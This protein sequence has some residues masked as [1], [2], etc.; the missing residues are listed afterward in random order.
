MRSFAN[1]CSKVRVL[2]PK[3]LDVLTLTSM[4]AMNHFLAP[5]TTTQH[6][7]G[8]LTMSTII[9]PIPDVSSTQCNT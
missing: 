6:N 4:S 5:M 9:I 1:T 8:G 2:S 7:K 3:H